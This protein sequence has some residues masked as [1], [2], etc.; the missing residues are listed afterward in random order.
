M[1]VGARSTSSSA[2]PRRGGGR[3]GGVRVVYAARFLYGLQRHGLAPR[4]RRLGLRPSR[5]VLARFQGT[6]S[7]SRRSHRA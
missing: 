1:G 4:P 7:I 2:R 6:A 5:L 3:A